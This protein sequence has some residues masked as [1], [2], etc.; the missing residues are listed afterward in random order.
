MNFV[1]MTVGFML[2]LGIALAYKNTLKVNIGEGIF[3][4][5][6]T[7]VLAL[8]L[9]GLAGSFACGMYV[10][11]AIAAAGYVFLVCRTARGGGGQLAFL[12]SPYLILIFVLF[13]WS[14]FAYYHDF[15]QHI[16]EFHHWALAVKYMLRT[17]LLAHHST[18]FGSTH[19]YATSLFYLFFQRITGYSEQNM[20][21]ASSLLVWIGLLL[22]FAG[23]GGKDWKKT[24]MY[25]LILYFALFSLYAYGLKSLYVD[26][27][28]AAWA[29]GLA[30]WWMNREKKKTDY[31][32]LASGLLMIWYFKWLAGPLIA[33]FALFFIIVH[34]LFVEKR[35]QE[36][37][38][39]KE[40]GKRR[41]ILRFAAIVAL[42]LVTGV[43]VAGIWLL[44]APNTTEL[45]ARILGRPITKERIEDT[46][47]VFASGVVGRP[48]ASKSNLKVA[49]VPFLIALVI[50][51]KAIADLFRQKRTFIVYL[52]Y[53]LSTSCAFL[54]ILFYA[55][56]CIFNEEEAGRMASGSR[57][58]SLYVIFI[59][60]IM[61]VWLLQRKDAQLPR[62]P[63]YLAAGILLL[64]L[65]GVNEKF[66][67]NAT[68]L[69]PTK[70]SGHEQITRS[71]GQ[72]KKIAKLLEEDDRVYFLDQQ[73][74]GEYA[75]ATAL[76]YL[77]EQV[78]N[79]ITE[80]W[81]F[82]K[83][84]NMTR[85]TEQEEPQ[86]EDF[87][88]LLADGGYTYLWIYR[89]D[90]FLKKELPEVLDCEDGVKSGKLYRV[91]YEDGMAVRLEQV[92]N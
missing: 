2:L 74:K 8:F 90:G 45:L 51:M 71:S 16:D 88:R 38:V 31:L 27:P 87:P 28:V 34:T 61:M 50:W 63:G 15:I 80:P 39:S 18:L 64:F 23:Y 89:A 22:P 76:Y 83:T 24:A 44:K 58:L 49:F 48:L 73:G 40:P 56:L 37:W 68:A 77:E 5:V 6:P 78:S 30:G 54:G 25:C 12:R 79:Y 11:L 57:Y 85:M 46:V 47:G 19:P 52:L 66:I 1:R 69:Y 4:T 91:V 86:I 70:I 21:V 36:M 20:Y 26:V 3:L 41:R 84:G 62:V 43:T 29:G 92:K 60:V 13:I 65:G 53:T 81:K 7:V 67:P 55:Y 10:L 82:T 14:L 33:L 35:V 59:F 75:R 17:D 9:G 42:C 72:A 32:V